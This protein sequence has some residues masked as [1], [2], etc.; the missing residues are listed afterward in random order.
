MTFR[1][2]YFFA[3]LRH[4]TLFIQLVKREVTGRYRG[5]LLGLFW[6]FVTPLLMLSVYSFVFVGVFSMR[7]PGAES[8]GGTIYVLQLFAGLIVFN[9]FA[10]VVSRAPQQI[11]EQPNLVKRV[12]FP[13]ELLAHVSI[14]VALVHLTISSAILLTTLALTIGVTPQILLIPLAL[15]PLIFMALGFCWML[16]ALGVYVRDLSQ[17]IGVAVSLLLFLSPIFYS[18]D[19]LPDLIRKWM[20]ANPL[21][22]PIEN[23]RHCILPGS[24]GI[25]WQTWLISL[26]VGFFVAW[27]GASVFARIRDGFPDVV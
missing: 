6:A 18:T 24:K 7:W 15:L 20:V 21:V 5:S 13:L 23:L 16:S 25:D 27:L 10:E 12:V 22:L 1:P 17:F 26:L 11:L 3:S 9:F 2:D 8:A 19:R 14:S 4:Q